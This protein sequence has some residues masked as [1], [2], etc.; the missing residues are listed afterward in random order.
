M[1]DPIREENNKKQHECCCQY[2][3]WVNELPFFMNKRRMTIDKRYRGKEQKDNNYPA[4]IYSANKKPIDNN[5]YLWLL[6]K[7]FKKSIIGV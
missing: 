2:G 3:T 4:N 5:P 7:S 6:R 1:V